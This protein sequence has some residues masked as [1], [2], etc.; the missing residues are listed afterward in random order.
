MNRVTI[1]EV[2]A[3]LIAGAVV[4]GYFMPGAISP[5]VHKTLEAAMWIII[6]Y[7]YGSSSGSAKKTDLM[8]KNGG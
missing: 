6:G 5:E 7:Y 1:K 3:V 2:L 8:S 4:I